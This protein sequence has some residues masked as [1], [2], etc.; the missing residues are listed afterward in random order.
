MHT[1]VSDRVK[2]HLCFSSTVTDRVDT[3]QVP[4]CCNILLKIN[5]VVHVI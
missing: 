5:Y 3:S 2:M 4:M 1:F